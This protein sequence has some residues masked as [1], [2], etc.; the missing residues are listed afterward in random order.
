MGNHDRPLPS[1][2]SQ[3]AVVSMT[4]HSYTIEVQPDFIERQAK[5]KPVPAVTELIWNSPGRRRDASRRTARVRRSWLDQDRRAGQ[6]HGFHTMTP[7]DSS[8]VSVARGRR[9]GGHTKTKNRMLH[10]YEDGAGWSYPVSAK[11]VQL[12]AGNPQIEK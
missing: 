7:H 9:P 2:I 8:R 6:R 4:E 10:G 12:L 1:T 5:A 3:Q 11:G